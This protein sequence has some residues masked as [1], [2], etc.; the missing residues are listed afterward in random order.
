MHDYSNHSS[1]CCPSEMSIQVDDV[2]VGDDVLRSCN[3][4]M[5]EYKATSTSLVQTIRGEAVFDP[6]RP[7]QNKSSSLFVVVV[8]W[9][10]RVGSGFCVE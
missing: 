8:V 10:G 4:D 3:P 7:R 2:V 5:V 1:C 9:W 6:A